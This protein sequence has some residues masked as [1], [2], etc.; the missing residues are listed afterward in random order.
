MPKHHGPAWWLLYALVLLLTWLFVAEHRT[1][2]TP[3]WHKAVQI[4]IVLCI[5]GLA[6]LWLRAN[7]VRPLWGDQGTRHQER[8]V[9]PRGMPSSLSR[10]RLALRKAYFFGV[11]ARHPHRRIHPEA[12][13]RR[14]RKCSVNF[15][16]RLS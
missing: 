6:W 9:K 3:G 7:A 13:R 16:Q 15:D 10:A 1:P 12:K 2:L 4:G 11:R 5:Y 8:A 14:I